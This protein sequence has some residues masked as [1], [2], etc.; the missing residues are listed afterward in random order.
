MIF[1]IFG[2][3]KCVFERK[4]LRCQFISESDIFKIDYNSMI[5]FNILERNFAF[6]F[7]V[8]SSFVRKFRYI[9]YNQMLICCFNFKF[10]I[11]NIR[12]VFAQK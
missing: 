11:C 9:T 7:L 6:S 5:I 1:R 4:N 2:L 3:V 10:I 8:L 12:L